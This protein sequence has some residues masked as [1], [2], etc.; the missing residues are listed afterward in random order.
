MLRRLDQCSTLHLHTAALQ[1]SQ[2]LCAEHLVQP[3]VLYAW[4]SPRVYCQRWAWCCLQ[5]EPMLEI[6]HTVS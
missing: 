1:A 5:I 3:S 6:Q 2:Q 4:C